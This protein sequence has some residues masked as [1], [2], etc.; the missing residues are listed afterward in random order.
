LCKVVAPL[1]AKKTIP[2]DAPEYLPTAPD[3][4]TLGTLSAIGEEVKI[5]G[6]SETA[7]FTEKGREERERREK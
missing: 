1:A 3:L 5:K 2:Y 4:H 6:L 7:Q